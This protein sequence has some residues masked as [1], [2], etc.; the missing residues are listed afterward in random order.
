MASETS[1]S[2]L[3]FVLFY[4]LLVTFVSPSS[5]IL[6]PLKEDRT[7]CCTGF[8]KLS[9]IAYVKVL[10]KEANKTGSTPSPSQ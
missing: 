10:N 1:G 7:I 4:W 8:L 6:L 2:R 9:K 3:T 5:R